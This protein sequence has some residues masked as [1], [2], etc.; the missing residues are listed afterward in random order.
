M[1]LHF[2]KVTVKQV[3]KET[4]DCVSIVFDIP[5][6]LQ[7]KFRYKQGQHLTMRAFIN[8]EEVRRSYSLCSSPLHNEWRVAVKKVDGGLFSTYANS[9]LKTGDTLELME[10]MGHFFTELDATS[11]KSYV[12]IASGSGITPILS[13]IKTVLITEPES[14]FT[15]VYGN[16]NRSSVIFK[17]ELEALKNKYINRFRIVYV[18]SRER[19]DAEINHGRIDAKKCAVL[20]NKIVSINSDEFFICGPEEMIFT[21]KDFLEQNGVE[22]KKI[23]FELFSSGGIVQRK[24]KSEQEHESTERKS[25]ITVKLDGV[26]FDFQVPFNGNAILDEA[27][28]NG[29]DLPYSCKGGVCCTCKARLLEGEVDMDVSYGLEAEEIDE[30]FI[31]ACQ[32]HP[33]T[34]KVVID[35]DIK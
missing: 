2:E 18:L 34:E 8:D 13:I 14:E 32:A 35:F 16:R 11:K 33:K 9:A 7:E 27:L 5:E 26:T 15:L 25:S 1:S 20:F 22:K 12:A 21:V 3:K 29:A 19:T 23:H 4:A 6:T 28:K 24:A 30:G 10:P 17:E 31:L